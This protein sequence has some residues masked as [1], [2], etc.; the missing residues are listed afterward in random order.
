MTIENEENNSNLN[1]NGN[2]WKE[3]YLVIQGFFYFAQGGAVAAILMFV[4]FLQD[5]LGVESVDAIKYQSI[6][7]LP[8]YFKI[9]IGFV[10][11]K[12]PIKNFGKRRP[13]ILLAVVFGLIGWFTLGNFNEFNDWVL[14]MG[15]FTSG[16]VAIADTIFDSMGVDLAPPN[17]RSTMQGVGWGFRGLGGFV[18]GISFG[19]I[20]NRIGWNAGFMIFGGLMTLG[21]IGTLLMKEARDEHGKI[22]LSDVLL[23]D[24]K[25]E[26]SKKITWI[27]VIF[28]LFGGA[29]LA[30][31][32]LISDFLYNSPLQISIENLGLTFS[33]FSLGQFIGAITAGYL[34][35][36]FSPKWILL[37]CS[38]LY[39]GLLAFF[40]TNPFTSLSIAYLLI[41]LLGTINGSYE[42]TQMRISME[43]S[44]GKLSGTMFSFYNSMANIGQIALG[45]LIINALRESLGNY[46]IAM[47]A[48]S[49]FILITLW[50]G[51]YLLK[52][53]TSRNSKKEE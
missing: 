26:F 36:K 48:A 1:Q 12:Y 16:S 15:I 33:L 49:I 27:T 5:Q 44:V 42:A 32:V 25:H 40:L 50:P 52:Q 11:D 29:A 6:I 3:W 20:V 13:Y 14:V 24:V 41:A 47:Q 17:R 9:I 22:L 46:L 34:G 51:F 30:V 4:V 10:S 18:S 7:M 28:N 35:Q 8:W 2:T 37:I 39:V 21:G 19:L 31:I 53:L 45:A 43:F 23:K 38:G